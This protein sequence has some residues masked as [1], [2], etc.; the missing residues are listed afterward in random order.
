MLIAVPSKNRAGRT[1]T[2]KILPNIA[3]FFVPQ[4]E[5]HQYHYIKNVVAVPNEIQGITNT[6]NWILKNTNEKWVVFL[7]DDAKNVGYTEL[8]R[9]QA[10]KIE[11]KEEGFWAEEFLK[12]FDFKLSFPNIIKYSIAFVILFPLAGIG[13]DFSQI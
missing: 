3:T 11:I 4:S 2:N 1:T 5:V 9:T 7:D 13:L 12:A 6:R 8:G 10:K